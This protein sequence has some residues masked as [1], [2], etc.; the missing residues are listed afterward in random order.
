[1]N[2]ALEIS[3][4][5]LLVDLWGA[6]APGRLLRGEEQTLLATWTTKTAMMLQA[7]R[8]QNRTAS[9]EQHQALRLRLEPPTGVKVWLGQFGAPGSLG[10]W[11]LAGRDHLS[12]ALPKP[13]K[14]T[15][16]LTTFVF[17]TLLLQVETLPNIDLQ[18]WRPRLP[19]IWP[20]TPL[21]SWPPSSSIDEEQLGPIHRRAN[22]P[23][24]R[25]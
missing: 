11:H 3:M 13:S 18:V 24:R 15:Y 12:L 8:P 16:G 23:I 5:R 7:L 17:H 9:L 2:T 10:G 6:A 21:L 25:P 20:I 1:M 22:Y 14:I 4:K 19:T